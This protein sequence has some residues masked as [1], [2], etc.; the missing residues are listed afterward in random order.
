MSKVKYV[1]NP[2]SKNLFD[3]VV[4]EVEFAKKAADTFICDVSAQVGDVVRHTSTPDTVEV[5]TSNPYTGKAFG[6]IIEKISDTV[7]TVQ[8]GGKIAGAA[9]GL[10]GLTPGETIWI[11]TNGKYTTTVPG[12]GE[13]QQAMGFAVKTDT[14][15]LIPDMRKVLKS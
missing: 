8:Y 13:H 4:N 6:T 2:L 11:G 14:I 10:S 15:M 12:S 1:V 3:A 9:N 7:C 5:I